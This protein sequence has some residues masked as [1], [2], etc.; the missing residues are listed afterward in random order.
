MNASCNTVCNSVTNTVTNAATN[1]ATNAVRIRSQP[2]PLILWLFSIAN[3]PK[4][5]SLSYL[6]REAV[7]MHAR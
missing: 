5:A 6:S 1:A 2:N 7:N 4:H 3:P